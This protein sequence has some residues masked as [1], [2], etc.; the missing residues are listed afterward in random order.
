[1]AGKAAPG[2]GFLRPTAAFS[3]HHRAALPGF[4]ARRQT[5]TSASPRNPPNPG[6][7]SLAEGGP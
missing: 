1:M 3:G 7:T 5:S 6:Q 4:A 2:A